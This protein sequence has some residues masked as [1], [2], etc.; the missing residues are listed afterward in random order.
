[1]SF[2]ECL[3]LSPDC[4][5][6]EIKAAYKKLAMMYHPDK[7]KSP[8]AAE[9]FNEI[10]TAYDILKDE[11]KR[12]NYDRMPPEKRT[13]LFDLIKEY[14]TDINPQYQY[15]FNNVINVIYEGNEFEL[16]DDVN[17]MNIRN[18]LAHVILKFYRDPEC[19]LRERKPVVNNSFRK[20]PDDN[21][22]ELYVKLKD[23]YENHP[24]QVSFNNHVYVVMPN[25]PVLSTDLDVPDGPDVVIDIRILDD[26]FF[27]IMNTHDLFTVR[28]VSLHDY[29]YGAV[30][31]FYHIDG[32]LNKLKIDSCL[33]KKPVFIL[34]NKGLMISGACDDSKGE[35]G[36]EN[37]NTR[38]N[39]YIY[40][41]IEGVNSMI[42]T[43]TDREYNKTMK[44]T[45]KLMFPSI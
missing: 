9:K 16:Q 27:S 35:T 15:M 23:V 28:T 2:Y 44:D 14:F 8:D 30:I 6:Q 29:I 32:G 21:S 37:V 22:Y 12:A 11:T 33:E 17:H 40:I 10:K 7:N 45:L 39:L 13:A 25:N 24:Q 26:P 36:I 31:K 3:G 18:I 1:M 4:S 5:Q 43:D 34:E 42:N 19:S 41:N 20:G 38:G